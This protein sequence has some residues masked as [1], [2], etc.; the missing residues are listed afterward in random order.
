MHQKTQA[1]PGQTLKTLNFGLRTLVVNACMGTSEHQDT[2]RVGAWHPIS[3]QIFV[4]VNQS[5]RT[6]LAVLGLIWANSGEQTVQTTV[7]FCFPKLLV[8]I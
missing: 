5:E 2:P 4:T 3:D 8:K 7:G 6:I 1:W